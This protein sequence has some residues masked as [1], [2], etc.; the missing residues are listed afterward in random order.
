MTWACEDCGLRCLECDERMCLT[1]GPEPSADP[2][3]CVDCA[4]AVAG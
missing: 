4:E 1:N 3:V 2:A